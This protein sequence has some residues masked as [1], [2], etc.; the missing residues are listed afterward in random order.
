MA[1][2][3]LAWIAGGR[4]LPATFNTG[5]RSARALASNGRS[6]WNRLAALLPLVAVESADGTLLKSKPFGSVCR[7]PHPL[8]PN[9]AEIAKETLDSWGT[10]PVEATKRKL[11]ELIEVAHAIKYL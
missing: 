7:E 1:K 9:L 5:R 2:A 6:L 3:N 4:S 11:E 8:P 10:K